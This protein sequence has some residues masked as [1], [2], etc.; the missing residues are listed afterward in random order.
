MED[1]LIAC[2]APTL[3]GKKVGNIFSM[4]KDGL[5]Y[6][7]LDYWNE[8]LNPYNIKVRLLKD[9]I[10]MYL[11]YVYREM[12]LD[13]LLKREDIKSFLHN[14]GYR[15]TKTEEMIENLTSRLED[16]KEFPHEIGVFLGYPLSDVLGFIKNKGKCYKTC[17]LWKVYGDK[18]ESERM[19][20]EFN[21]CK[22]CFKKLYDKG[23]K[24]LEIIEKYNG[25]YQ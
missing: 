23:Y 19:F 12:L 16:Y 8:K 20:S 21:H 10:S 17:G 25:G 3:A 5:N 13:E 18:V 2:C 14:Y 9:G 24:A 6:P 15:C 11:V 4:K 7:D 22:Y 1:Y